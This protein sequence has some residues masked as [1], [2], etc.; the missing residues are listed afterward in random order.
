RSGSARRG[1]APASPPPARRSPRTA[2]RRRGRAPS[3]RRVSPPT[4]RSRSPHSSPPGSTRPAPPPTIL[5]PPLRSVHP[6][7]A[8]AP[9][10]AHSGHPE[11]GGD[12]LLEDQEQEH[13]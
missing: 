11:R 8:G 12:L 6:R 4:G 3:P 9:R 10:S 2:S 1:P 13:Q 5:I 7:P